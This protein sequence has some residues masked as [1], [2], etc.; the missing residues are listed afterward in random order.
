MW[1][2]NFE[3]LAEQRH[4]NQKLINASVCTFILASVNSA[5]FCLAS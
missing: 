2:C 5:V 1:A 4:L 3:L